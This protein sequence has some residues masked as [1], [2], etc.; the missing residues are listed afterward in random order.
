M[1]RKLLLGRAIYEEQK[2]YINGM[3]FVVY[4]SH[5]RK[6]NLCY[7][8]EGDEENLLKLFEKRG[9]NKSLMYTNLE[10]SEE[11]INRYHR[12]LSKLKKIK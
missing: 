3:P 1:L 12:D 2:E 9:M 4:E 10:V 6:G 11:I 8:I 5:D 7:I